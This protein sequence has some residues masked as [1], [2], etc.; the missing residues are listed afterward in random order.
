MASLLDASPTLS[1]R[2]VTE[3]SMTIT[4]IHQPNSRALRGEARGSTAREE[5]GAP[6]S[7]GCTSEVTT[8]PSVRCPQFRHSRNIVPASAVTPESRWRQNNRRSSVHIGESVTNKD[9]VYPRYRHSRSANKTFR[10]IRGDSR[11]HCVALCRLSGVRPISQL[12]TTL[13]KRW[14]SPHY[15][16]LPIGAALQIAGPTGA[17]A[18]ATATGGR[19]PWERWKPSNARRRRLAS[20]GECSQRACPPGD[21]A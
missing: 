12:C 11:K 6:P 1:T 14:M 2:R 18:V 5:L 19:G 7:A 20:G 17:E 9:C 4:V 3:G 15:Q 13:P 21:E 16:W 10:P 8:Q